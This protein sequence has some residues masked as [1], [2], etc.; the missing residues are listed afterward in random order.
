M[1]K[2]NIFQGILLMVLISGVSCSAQKKCTNCGIVTGGD[3]FLN[4]GTG[5]YEYLENYGLDQKVWYRDSL[6]IERI[7]GLYIE[8]DMDGREK[9]YTKTLYYTFIDLRTLSFY[10]Y[11]S[12]SDTAKIIKKFTQSDTAL[13]PGGWNFYLPIDKIPPVQPPELLADTIL[14][15]VTYKRVKIV[16]D[17][18]T[19]YDDSSGKLVERKVPQVEVLYMRCDKKGTLFQLRKPLSEKLGCPIVRQDIL[20]SLYVAR[21]LSSQIHFLSETLTPEEI[22]VFDAW[23]KNAKMNPVK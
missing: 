7:L 23:E 8:E 16:C 20:P 6:V 21:P 13:V 2:H 17:S 4:P 1:Q 22:K 14:E 15:G 18:T 12:F 3:K 11:T 5:Q 10:D 9:R 19:F